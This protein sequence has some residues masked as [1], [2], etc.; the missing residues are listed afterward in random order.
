MEKPKAQATNV[1]LTIPEACEQLRVS[2]WSV[3]RLLGEN[4]LKSV[5]IRG[6]RLIPRAEVDNFI[7]A[8]LAEGTA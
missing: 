7:T 5:R 4:K 1:L 6:R 8:Q 3:Y 2:K